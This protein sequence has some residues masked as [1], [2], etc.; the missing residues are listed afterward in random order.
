MI[1]SAQTILFIVIIALT[2]LLF[3]LGIH[4]FFIL[5]DFRK[6]V[7][8]ANK[9]LDNTNI[10]TQSV[11]VPISAF[12]S[13]AMGIKTGSSLAGIFKK[14]ISKGSDYIEKKRGDANGKQ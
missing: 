11:S 7:S 8:K 6:T 3:V 13:I 5:R 9:V 4:L 12:S 1:D 2:V 10:I 14:I